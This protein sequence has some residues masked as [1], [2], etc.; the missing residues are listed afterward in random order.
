MYDQKK[1]AE[2]IHHTIVFLGLIEKI[3]LLNLN[4]DE[5][6]RYL[7]MFVQFLKEQENVSGKT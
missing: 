6:L 4:Y 3:F 1:I 2:F 7:K 5:L